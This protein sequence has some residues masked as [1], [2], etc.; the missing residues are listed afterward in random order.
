MAKSLIFLWIHYLIFG[1]S[2]FVKNA[3]ALLYLTQPKED[4]F[5]SIENKYGIKILISGDPGFSLGKVK[6]IPL[7]YRQKNAGLRYRSS[8]LQVTTAFVFN[9]AEK[10]ERDKRK[11]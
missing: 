10:L 8:N 11:K 7:V 5:N 4:L 1:F 3:I 9:G 2:I 6:R